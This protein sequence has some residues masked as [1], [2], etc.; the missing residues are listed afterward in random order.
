MPQAFELA[1]IIKIQDSTFLR[2]ISRQR[3]THAIKATIP[4][5]LK[6]SPLF[7]VIQTI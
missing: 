6:N 7:F 4:T 5:I 2:S 3:E 1:V